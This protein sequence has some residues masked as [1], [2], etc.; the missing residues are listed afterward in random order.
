[1]RSR[2]GC[3][4]WLG[5]AGRLQ[6]LAHSVDDRRGIAVAIGQ[7]SSVSRPGLAGRSG[8][9]GLV[10]WAFADQLVGAVRRV[11]AKQLQ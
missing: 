2:P 11:G 10:W 8:S 4:S 3:I 6:V 7:N 1:M 5:V 9:Y